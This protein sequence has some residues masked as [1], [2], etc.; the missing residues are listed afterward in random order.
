MRCRECNIDVADNITRCPLCGAEVFDDE[1]ALGELSNIPY[2]TSC[3]PYPTEKRVFTPFTAAKYC[4]C[5]AVAAGTVLNAAG[6]AAKNE[7]LISAGAALAAASGAVSLFSCLTEKGELMKGSM[8]LLVS[9]AAA[10]SCALPH[11]K[12]HAVN[13]AAAAAVGASAVM[14]AV[15]FLSDP[16]GMKEQ[17]KAAFRIFGE[18]K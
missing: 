3:L 15:A 16:D 9:T 2:P 1:P 13:R 6:R 14:N 18:Q 7:K 8:P 4:A 10:V 11:G 5:A 12:K 17:Y